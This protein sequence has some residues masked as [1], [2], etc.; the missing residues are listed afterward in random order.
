MSIKELL[1]VIGL[2]TLSLTSI[3]FLYFIIEPI[4][5]YLADSGHVGL[6]IISNASIAVII[7]YLVRWFNKKVNRLT[8]NEYGFTTTRALRNFFIGILVATFLVILTLFSV[9]LFKDIEVDFISLNSG[10]LLFEFIIA[11]LVVATWEEMYFRGLV[12]NTLLKHKI[13]FKWTATISSGLFAIL[14][15]ASYDLETITPFWIFGVFFISTILFYLYIL[16]RSIWTSIGCHFCWDSLFMSIDASE[17]SFGIIE[18]KTYAVHSIFIDN[19]SIL[20]TGVVLT[21]FL[22]FMKNEIN[23]RV[24]LYLSQIK[25]V[26]K[27]D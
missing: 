22:I 11:N 14:H 7:F 23:S 15:I 2:I 6:S 1:K 12:V 19:I 20:I 9:S 4:T 21:L 26:S 24:Q 27:S 17:N 8:I 13:N 3:I 10:L 5:D 18:M 16:T 25:I